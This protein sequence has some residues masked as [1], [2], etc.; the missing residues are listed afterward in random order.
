MIAAQ[1][2]AVCSHRQAANV[3]A[4]KPFYYFEW[5]SSMQNISSSILKS[6]AILDVLRH[7]I[8]VCDTVKSADASLSVACSIA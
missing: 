3:H 8:K 5:F 1:D 7:C 4:T 2:P 6:K